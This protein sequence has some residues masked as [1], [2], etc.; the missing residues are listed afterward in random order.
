MTSRRSVSFSVV[1]S[2]VAGVAMSVCAAAAQAQDQTVT[3]TGSAGFSPVA[4]WSAAGRGYQITLQSHTW[5]DP[6]NPIPGLQSFASAVSGD[7]RVMVAGRTNGLHDFTESGT[8]NFPPH[9]Q[10]V[11]VYVV[12]PV[13]KQ[14]WRRSLA[15]GTTLSLDQISRLSATNTQSFQRGDGFFVVGGYGAILTSASYSAITGSTTIVSSGSFVTHNSLT[16]IH[17]PELV[18]W[19]KS[20]TAAAPTSLPAS[21]VTQVSGV[22]DF[23]AVT[24]GEALGTANGQVHLVFG[25]TFPGPYTGSSN[26]I[27]TSQVRSFTVDYTPGGEGGAPA[28][29]Y[30]PISTSPEPGD[31]TLFRRRDLNV[32]P[33]IRRDPTNPAAVQEGMIAYAGVFTGTAIATG[34][35]TVSSAGDGV[36]TLPVEISATGTPT[37]IGTTSTASSFVQPMNQSA[38]ANLSMYSGSTGDFTT[39]MFGGI[40]ANT[41]DPQSGTLTYQAEYPFTNQITA[42]T[43]DLTGAYSQQ[44]VGEYPYTPI[45]SGTRTFYLYGAEAKFFAS[46]GLPASAMYPNG[47]LKLDDLLALGSGTI[48]YIFGG[49]VSSTFNTSSRLDSTASPEIFSV[50]ITPVPE[51]MTCAMAVAGIACGGFSMWRRKRK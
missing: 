39:F 38:S 16:A 20:G 4:N 3:G 45:V 37:M 17:L 28:L 14:T 21:A 32:V 44:Y 31:E 19:V 12:N 9:R 33:S 29:S 8:A 34:T 35:G 6:A 43:R 48:G 51:P 2:W 5:S 50:I 26:G 22:S 13:S 40:T 15:D 18:G 27:Y 24:G 25:P 42:V 49:I 11:D 36:W 30:T 46:P 7:E 23:F 47:V 41:Y 10:N 1:A